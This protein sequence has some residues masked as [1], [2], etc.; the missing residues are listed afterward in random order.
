MLIK[1]HILCFF[2]CFVRVEM[3]KIF[4]KMS[5]FLTIS[6]GS[7]ISVREVLALTNEPNADNFFENRKGF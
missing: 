4:G 1:C 7:G 6:H 5:H 3:M 2:E